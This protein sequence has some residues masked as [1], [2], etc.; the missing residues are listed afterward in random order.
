MKLSIILI[1]IV[2]IF[3]SCKHQNKIDEKNNSIKQDTLRY[4]NEI[5]LKNIKQLTFGGDNAEHIG[6]LMIQN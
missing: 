6:V 4:D 1:T 5:H 3:L 2:T